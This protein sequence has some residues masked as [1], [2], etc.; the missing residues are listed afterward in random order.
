VAFTTKNQLQF[1]NKIR[2]SFLAAFKEKRSI[3]IDLDKLADELPE[4]R[5]AW[6]YSEERQQ[7]CY[8]CP[9]C[10]ARYDMLGEY[11]GCP[12]CGKRNSFQVF[13]RHVTEVEQQFNKAAAELTERHEREV[14]WEK[15]SRCIS[16]FEAMARDVQGQLHLFPATPKRKKD[17]QG[18]SF[19]NILKANDSLLNWFGFEMLFRF[20]DDDK[21]FLNRMFNRRHVLIHNG[22]RIDQEYLDNTGDTTVRLNQKI[23]V[24]SNEIRRLFPLLRTVAQNLFQ[25]FESIA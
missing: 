25:G 9:G 7:N 18:M 23:V 22:G 2:E 11:A 17:I 24:R 15:L 6:I 16:D 4:N 14:E 19:Q 5:P 13:E 1:I 21:T 3:T 10:K 12:I 8:E 20:S